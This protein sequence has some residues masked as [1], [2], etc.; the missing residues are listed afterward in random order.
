MTPCPSPIYI[1]P[2]IQIDNRFSLGLSYKTWRIAKNIFERQHVINVKQFFEERKY[3]RPLTWNEKKENPQAKNT[4]TEKPKQQI[5]LQ[6][7]MDQDDTNQDIDIV[8]IYTHTKHQ[9]QKS[10]SQHIKHLN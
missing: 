3:I 4:T 10:S 8:K 7:I 6:S 9:N 5:T 1:F 2:I